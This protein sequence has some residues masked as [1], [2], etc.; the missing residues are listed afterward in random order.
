MVWSLEQ[1][2]RGVFH[3]LRKVVVEAG[4]FPDVLLYQPSNDINKAAFKL[5]KEAI[6]TAQ[7]ELIHVF[8]AGDA[9][10]RDAEIKNKIIVDRGVP[11][12][13]DIGY[14][15]CV[16]FKNIGTIGEVGTTYRKEMAPAFTYFVPYE[17]TYMC[18]STKYDRI[19]EGFIRKALT[20]TFLYGYDENGI[21]LTELFNFMY[22]SN[23]VNMTNEKYIERMYKFTAG[24]V[25]LDE[26]DVLETTVVQLTDPLP[27]AYPTNTITDDLFEQSS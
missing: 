7:K 18:S 6:V 11:R 16:E 1:L 14:F 21:K 4:Y 5:A 10:S 27:E 23:P 17:I 25:I 8:G 22:D 15:G 24:E 20:K 3:A 9:S 26:N 19:L 12:K 13:A 2:D